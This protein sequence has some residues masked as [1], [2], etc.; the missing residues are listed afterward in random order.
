MSEQ[1]LFPGL[2]RDWSVGQTL[3][4]ITKKEGQTLQRGNFTYFV[5]RVNESVLELHT[6]R[7]LEQVGDMGAG[8][9]GFVLVA[10]TP[11]MSDGPVIALPFVIVPSG[12]D[13]YVSNPEYDKGIPVIVETGFS[14]IEGPLNA[15]EA[16]LMDDDYAENTD[17]LDWQL[18][19]TAH[20]PA[21][22]WG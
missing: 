5:Q 9:R 8:I 15:L 2:D 11:E 12:G 17:P 16:L 13:G 18:G 14:D 19:E 6:Y 4:A 1:P 21:L 22:G 7:V 20:G 3:E 10:Y